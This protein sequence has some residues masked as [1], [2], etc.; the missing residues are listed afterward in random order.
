MHLL[1]VSDPLLSETWRDVVSLVSLVLSV[2]G[3]AAT[4][5]G[6]WYAIDQIRKTKSAAVAAKEA[7]DQALAESRE[8]YNRYAAANAHRLIREAKI[9]VQSGVAGLTQS[10]STGDAL[11]HDQRVAW[12]LA[13]ARLSDLA[14]QVAQLAN[15]DP[16][17]RNFADEL[18]EWEGTCQRFDRGEI[19]RFD[20]KK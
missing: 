7:A 11:T 10:Q 5:L 4:V 3:L 9:H 1:A 6:L 19:K 15:D 20:K 8:S 2:L 13:A 12:V 16:D 17:W 14:D 18:R